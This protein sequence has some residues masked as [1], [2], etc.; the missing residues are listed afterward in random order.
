MTQPLMKN[1]I[2]SV[3]VIFIL[4][5]SAVLL[6]MVF[7][8]SRSNSDNDDIKNINEGDNFSNDTINHD[9]I[10]P[11]RG[12]FYYAW[13]PNNWTPH[14]FHVTYN[15]VGGYYSSNDRTTVNRQISALEYANVDL[16]I[17]S[18]WGLA[19]D[20]R[21][22][23]DS[24][25]KMC[26]EETDKI[27]TKGETDLK[28]A[29]YY[30]LESIDNEPASVI[31]ENLN[32]LKSRYVEPHSCYAHVDGKPVI[33]VY[34]KGSV[35]NG[36]EFTDR[37]AEAVGNDWYYVL[38]IYTGYRNVIK[39]PGSWHQYG[40]ATRI[41]KVSD[42]SGKLVSYNISPGFKH[43]DPNVTTFLERA[44]RE[45][46]TDIVKEMVDSKVNWQL[47][48][49]F[50]EWGEGTAI[51]SAEQWQTETGYGMYLDVLHNIH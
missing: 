34:S 39:Q 28:W 16:A 8:C 41:H 45:L 23:S 15:P 42:S 5:A 3:K 29:V 6:A 18:W 13:Y 19:N 33:F 43:A 40:P 14:G 50:N 51:E 7:A 48:T 32:Y 9:L 1:I 47:I 25:I 11:V 26:L 30:E 49:S 36:E 44:D 24:A 2:N 31:R 35:D 22:S 38:K 17:A 4:F 20:N 37:W 21:K 12:V 27:S 10:F 46:W